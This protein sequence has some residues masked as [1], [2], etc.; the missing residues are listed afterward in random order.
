RL[1]SGDS[2]FDVPY[3]DRRDEV[4]G[5]AKALAVFKDN[6]SAVH[7]MHAEQEELKRKA[8]VEKR[9]VMVDLAGQF[10]ASV[11]AVVRDVFAE[12]REMQQ[13]AQGMSETANKATERASFVASA[14]Q[15][16]SN[17]VQTVASAAGELSSSISEISQRV[18]R[19]AQVADKAAADG[20]RTNDTVQ[21]LA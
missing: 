15:Q 20:Q 16:A 5:L 12:A 19:A 21:G 7:Q 17:N 11:Q 2:A 4:G 10:E 6:A 13:A 3:T 18:A 1:A 9:K 8:D 14:C